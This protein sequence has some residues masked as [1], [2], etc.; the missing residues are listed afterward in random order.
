MA[1]TA[2]KAWRLAINL[3]QQEIADKMGVTRETYSS[4]EQGR[5]MPTV[6]SLFAMEEV[7]GVPARAIYESFDGYFIINSVE[8]S[9]ND[10]ADKKLQ[11]TF[12]G[13]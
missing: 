8:R 3:S 4:Y 2:L 1:N 10:G 11:T 9:K 12:E 6:F 13:I 7:L 5:R